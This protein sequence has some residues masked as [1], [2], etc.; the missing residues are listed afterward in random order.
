VAFAI[1]GL[2]Q[3]VTKC[4]EVFGIRSCLP[5]KAH[6]CHFVWL[7]RTRNERPSNRQPASKNDEFPSPHA[8]SRLTVTPY[9]IAELMSAVGQKQT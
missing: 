3:T 9:Q 7:L 8:P 1:P 2:A 4:V 6:P 5:Q